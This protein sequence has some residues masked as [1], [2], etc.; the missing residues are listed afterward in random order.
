[1]GGNQRAYRWEE[2]KG[3]MGGKES[4]EGKVWEEI[5]VC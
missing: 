4:K 1:M 5:S 2:I 3:R